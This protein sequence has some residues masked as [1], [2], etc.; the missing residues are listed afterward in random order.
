MN[1]IK[2]IDEIYG[3]TAKTCT[4]YLNTTLSFLRC[5]I[6]SPVRGNNPLYWW[7]RLASIQQLLLASDLQSGGVTNFPT[8]P[9]KMEE[10]KGF[11][12]LVDFTPRWFSKPVP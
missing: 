5:R 10:M 1:M 11:E 4:S 7:S 8:T 6:Y 9:F 12:P 2:N 3:G